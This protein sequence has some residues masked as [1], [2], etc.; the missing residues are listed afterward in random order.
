M[1]EILI[2]NIKLIL[3]MVVSWCMSKYIPRKLRKQLFPY[4]P[5]ILLS[6]IICAVF[7]PNSQFLGYLMMAGMYFC[8][9]LLINLGDI[10][11]IERRVFFI[12]FLA[13]YAYYNFVNVYAHY[14]PI[15]FYSKTQGFVMYF[16]P[17]I[18]AGVYCA[19]TSAVQ[20]L[21]RWVSVVAIIIC[22]V[23]RVAAVQ[24]IDVA[25]GERA[26]MEGLNSNLLGLFMVTLLTFALM[27]LVDSK[28]RWIIRVVAGVATL[29][30]AYI[31]ILTGSRNSFLGGLVALVGSSLMAKRNRIINICVLSAVFVIGGLYFIH[32][33]ATEDV[34]VLNK[35][36]YENDSGRFEWWHDLLEQTTPLQNLI[37]RGSYYDDSRMFEGIVLHSNMHSIY[38]QVYYEMGY[39]GCLLFVI[40]LIGHVG[41][42]LRNKEYGRYSLVY[43][44]TA[45]VCGVGESYSLR[46][47]TLSII[48]GLSIGLLLA[49]P[50]KQVGGFQT[51][52]KGNRYLNLR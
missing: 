26:S 20:S 52:R 16:L 18:M 50:G 45:L 10:K 28:E 12:W 23:Y 13:F 22:L 48:W 37:G 44:A 17:G 2:Q 5:A 35:E 27:S 4:V 1:F 21:N 36:N 8:I 30:S 43:L 15:G 34:R 19:S 39:V 11:S 32:S 9:T 40:Y 31:L 25:A 47:G 29:F 51:S 38:A 33:Y 46:G 7:L 6:T 3:L 41:T 14:A 24:T 49:K 42:A